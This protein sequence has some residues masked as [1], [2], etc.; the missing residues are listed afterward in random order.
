MYFV[1]H[2]SEGVECR[3]RRL[4]QRYLGCD[5]ADEVVFA[6]LVVEMESLVVGSHPED[7]RVQVL[8]LS[9]ECSSFSFIP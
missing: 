4:C 8:V 5:C 3:T 6:L 2:G 1:S 7:I 9:D